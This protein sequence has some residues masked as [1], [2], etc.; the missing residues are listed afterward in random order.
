MGVVY[1]ARDVELLRDVALKLLPSELS[2]DP[3]RLARMRREALL[4]A[5]INHPCV[6]TIFQA[7]FK[8]APHF[9]VMEFVSGATLRQRLRQGRMPAAEANEVVTKMAEGLPLRTRAVSCTAIS[10]PRTLW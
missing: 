2:A 5:R 9:L 3:E 6:A 7:S 10:S 8:Q 1:L 4:A